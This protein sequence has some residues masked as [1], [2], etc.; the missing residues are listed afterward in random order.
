MGRLPARRLAGPG[1]VVVPGQE[2]AADLPGFGELISDTDEAVLFESDYVE[3][4][5]IWMPTGE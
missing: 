3:L 5:A 1:L 2:P 4:I